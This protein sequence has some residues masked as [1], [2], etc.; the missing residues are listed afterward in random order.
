MHNFVYSPA[1][2]PFNGN[3]PVYFAHPPPSSQPSFHPYHPTTPTR[4]QFP[5]PIFSSPLPQQTLSTGTDNSSTDLSSRFRHLKAQEHENKPRN[6]SIND[7]ERS[8]SNPYASTTRFNHEHHRFQ[9]RPQTF[10]EFSSSNTLNNNNFSRSSNNYRYPKNN[11]NASLPLSA[12]MNTEQSFN[13]DENRPNN[14]WTT[15]AMHSRRR[16][17]PQQQQQQRPYHQ[18]KHQFPLSSYDPRQYGFNENSS[19]RN[20]LNNRSNT[21]KIDQGNSQ[22][23]GNSNEIDLIEEWWEDDN[24]DLI[25]TETKVTATVNDSGNSSLSTSMNLKE[26]TSDISTTDSMLNEQIVWFDRKNDVFR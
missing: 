15:T 13:T 25:G 14:H 6:I 17:I 11:N 7:F 22:L 8:H 20:N 5:H 3:G 19:K 1:A 2:V 26:I 9:F 12:Y 18:D 21:N 4:P 16:I 24:A 23:E 10:Y